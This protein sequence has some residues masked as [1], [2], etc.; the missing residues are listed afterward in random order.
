M[1]KSELVQIIREEIN[2]INESAISKI[3]E[4]KRMKL[5]Q[6]LTS[7]AKSYDKNYYVKDL[8]DPTQTHAIYGAYGVDSENL[9]SMKEQLKKL[10][11][12]YFRVVRKKILCFDASG[13]QV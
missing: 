6:K 8:F 3:P 11:A 13:I 1:K 9:T 5:E 12:K 4:S 10:G 7:F 2:L